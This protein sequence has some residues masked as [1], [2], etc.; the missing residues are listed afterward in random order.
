MAYKTEKTE[1]G[2]DLVI[3]GFEKGIASSPYYGIGNIMNLNTS[4]YPGVA[5]VNYRRQA[6]TLGGTGFF[7]AGTHSVDE[8]NNSNWIFSD[9]PA[10]PTMTN[11]ISKAVSPLS[12]IYI[13]DDSGQIWKQ[14][15]VNSSTF[16]ILEG[17][18]GRI[19]DG[20][21]GI[22]FWNNY[23]VVFGDGLIE[24][25]GDGSGDAGVIST[26]WNL[27]AQQI[28]Y[29]KILVTGV[30][31]PSSISANIGSLNYVFVN[32]PVQFTTTGALPSPLVAGTTYYITTANNSTGEVQVSSTVGGVAITITTTGSGTI[33]MIDTMNI[34]P[35]G[36][37][38]RLDFSGALEVGD[39]DATI[40]TYV[41]PRGETVTAEWA[42]ASGLYNIITDAGDNIPAN[43]VRGSSTV[44][45]LSPIIFVNATT[46]PYVNLL[47]TTVTNYKPYVSKVDGSLLFCNGQFIGRIATSTSPNLSFDPSIYLSYSV[48]YGVTSIPEQFTDQVTGMVDLNSQLVVTGKRDVYAWDYISPST[49]S[50]SPVGELIVDSVN[51]LNNVYI[52]AGQKGNVYISNGY[53]A[54]LF[55]KIPD[56]ISGVLD[57][58]WTY[59]GLMTHRSKLF[60]QALAQT[61]S[62]TN[63]LAGIFSLI[64]S[65]SALGDNANGIVMES[66]NSYGLTPTS[67][68]LATGVLIDNNP[69]STGYDS[70]YSAWSNGASLGGIDYNDTSLWQ[71]YEPTI[72][73]DI[74][75]IGNILDKKSPGNIEFKLDRPMTSGDSIRMYWRPS[76]SDSYTLMGTTTTTQLSDYYPSNISQSQ[77]AQ[78]KVQMKCA[79]SGSSRIP[80]KEVRLHFN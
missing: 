67:G 37:S 49:S 76:L 38:T 73:T 18:T 29:N 3:D 43:F 53:S 32:D 30:T 28:N 75:P 45:F 50:P 48:S 27:L 20:N 35:L 64:V 51:I 80:L 36:N 55:T 71:N 10:S 33:Y 8:G 41:N 66:Q 46:I 77:W 34:S 60:F 7:Y 47:D 5:Y 6:C 15:A 62:G 21:A 12:L 17:G 78:F 52:L 16:N 79:S 54:Q 13:Q 65:P 11:P 74:I 57:T 19:G 56:Y 23:L 24:F 14:S 25:C 40:A 69:S 22:A 44:N 2:R 68:A 63:I 26:N 59:G 70:Y 4:Y 61:T 1:T 42:E 31:S 72:E 58:V 39:T 9:A